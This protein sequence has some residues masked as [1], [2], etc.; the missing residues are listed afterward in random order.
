[1]N[2]QSEARV[3]ASHGKLI[4]TFKKAE[5]AYLNAKMKY[6]TAQA[7][8]NAEAETLDLLRANAREA[9]QSVQDKSAEVDALRQ[10]L[11]LDEREREVKLSELKGSRRTSFWG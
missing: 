11:A 4:H 1:M 3:Q 8:L 10:T 5:A 6:E 2:E 7:E 9:T